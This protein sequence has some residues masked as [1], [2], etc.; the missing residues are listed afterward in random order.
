MRVGPHQVQLEGLHTPQKAEK[1]KKGK[2]EETD[3]T[4]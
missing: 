4:F 1:G 2:W 3:E